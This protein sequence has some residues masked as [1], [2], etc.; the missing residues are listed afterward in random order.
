MATYTPVQHKDGTT[1]W[2]CRVFDGRKQYSGTGKTKTEARKQAE[3]KAREYSES[4]V[5]DSRMLFSRFGEE[6]LAGGAQ[7]WAASTTRGYRDHWERFIRP[8][9]GSYRLGELRPM[10]VQRFIES[11]STVDRKDRCR[12][13]LRAMLNRAVDFEMLPSNPALRLR[14]P[15][16]TSRP[17]MRWDADQRAAFLAVALAHPYAAFWA[18][19]LAFPAR[20]GEILGLHWGDVDLARR[21]LT[22]AGSRSTYHNKTVAGDTKTDSGRR[23][24][25]LGADVVAFLADWREQQR[26]QRRRLGREWHGE[27]LI[28]TGPKGGPICYSSLEHAHRRLVAAAGLPHISLYTLRHSMVSILKDAGVDSRTVADLAGHR[29][30]STTEDHYWRARPGDAERAIARLTPLPRDGD[31]VALAVGE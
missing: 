5:A 12:R 11:L 4:R 21:K 15:K 9:L 24:I 28:C 17:K 10:V 2:R 8:A 31:M 30:A 20:P 7:N 3:D 19:A 27:D 16:K 26:D 6:W 14:V 22:V 13:I 1:G 29:S 25:P 18:L 23:T